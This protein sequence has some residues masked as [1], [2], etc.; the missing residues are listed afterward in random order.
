[1]VRRSEH[2]FEAD[3][4]KTLLELKTFWKFVKQK[5][6]ACN[7]MSNLFSPTIGRFSE[8]P[9]ES[10][11]ILINQYKSVFCE[12]DNLTPKF[13]HKYHDNAFEFS[14][15]HVEDLLTNV[16][17]LQPKLSSGTDRVIAT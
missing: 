3:Q 2:R 10:P 17:S 9:V 16:S 12:A 5:T 15:I 6:D 14:E 4:A 8:T 13:S 7:P 11:E 1:M